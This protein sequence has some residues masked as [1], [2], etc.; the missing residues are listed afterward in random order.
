[1]VKNQLI[2]RMR[3][4]GGMLGFD[5]VNTVPDRVD[6]TNRDHLQTFNDLIYWAKKTKILDGASFAVLEKAGL[7]NERKAKEFLSEA[8]ELR[9]LIYAMF[10]PLSQHQ[11]IKPADLAAFNKL[12]LRY[13]P[14][15]EIGLQ[16][17]GFVEQW[18]FG[19]HIFYAI[20][21]PILK[22]AY[23]LLLS[24]KLHRVKQCPNC[25]WLFLDATKNGKRKWCSMQDCGSNVK[26]L[27]Y[28]YRKKKEK[29]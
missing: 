14:F 22:S 9:D 2:D 16:K 27:E 11:K 25:G 20:T 6:G 15:L 21:A 19:T 7:A 26:A 5:F 17:D 8:K 23:D 10:Q 1:M 24:D 3:L 4:D 18:N 13:F 29:E 12:V 28:Y